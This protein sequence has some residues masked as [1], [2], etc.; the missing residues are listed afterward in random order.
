MSRRFKRGRQ[1]LLILVAS[2]AARSPSQESETW[3][4]V[5]NIEPPR[6]KELQSMNGGC[7]GIGLNFPPRSTYQPSS[8]LTSCHASPERNIQPLPSI[9]LQA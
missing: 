2:R 7:R 9:P 4:Q 5:L 3:L 6:G 1:Y 8:A